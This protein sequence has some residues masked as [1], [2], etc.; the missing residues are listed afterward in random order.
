MMKHKLRITAIT[1]IFGLVVT[2]VPTFGADTT[3]DVPKDN[4]PKK[5]R[6]NTVENVMLHQITDSEVMIRWDPIPGVRGYCICRK[7]NRK[8]KYKEII[9]LKG[10]NTFMWSDKGLTR[11][12]T[13]F[14]SLRQYKFVEKKKKTKIIYGDYSPRRRISITRVNPYFGLEMPLG[15]NEDGT[16]SITV[17]NYKSA[18]PMKIHGT[19]KG[20]EAAAILPEGLGETKR[21]GLKL[22][23]LEDITDNK[24]YTPT[25]GLVEIQSGHT[26]RLTFELADQKLV[27]LKYDYNKDSF[28]FFVEY[29]TKDYSVEWSK[30]G[31]KHEQRI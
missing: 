2:L 8:D 14:Y 17:T 29:K 13:Y 12:K 27:P 22:W 11:G 15:L 4:L 28:I 26:A 1:L 5:E 10:D 21:I 25:D 6:L 24:T 9:R 18:L 20:E 16:L 3:K 7:E 23:K 31:G 30:E 19:I